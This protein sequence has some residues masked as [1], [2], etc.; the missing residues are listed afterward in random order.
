MPDI[1][2]S[3]VHLLLLALAVSG[4]SGCAGV[5]SAGTTLASWSIPYKIDIVQG[6]VITR[7]QLALLQPGMT[8]VAVREMLGTPLLTDVFHAERWD[9]AFTLRRQGVPDQSRKVTVFFKGNLLERTE[10][11][12]LPSEAEFVS[13]L[14]T[15]VKLGDKPALEASEASLRNFPP[16][17]PAPV[18]PAVTAAPVEYPP[19]E[20][21]AKK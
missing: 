2:I 6:N 1:T 12:P 10:A 3:R 16:P 19:L 5:G 4:L 14:R 21:S 17:K 11:D 8:R 9:F 18:P 13:T 15:T 7:E 20:S